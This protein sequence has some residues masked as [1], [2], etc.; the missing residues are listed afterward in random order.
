MGEI[1]MTDKL[2]R[3]C[4]VSATPMLTNYLEDLD[5][6]K[7]LPYFQLVFCIPTIL[8]FSGKPSAPSL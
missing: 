4:Y 3:L 6:F 2:Y 1:E 8:V 7:N 5:E